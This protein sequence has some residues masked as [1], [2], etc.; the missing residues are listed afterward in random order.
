MVTVWVSEARVVPE[1]LTRMKTVQSWGHSRGPP[2][3]SQP[4]MPLLLHSWAAVVS[5]LPLPVMVVGWV[6]ARSGVA[7]LVTVMVWGSR[8]R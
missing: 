5:T 8:W 7:A 2:Q 4:L 3:S 6:T 1:A